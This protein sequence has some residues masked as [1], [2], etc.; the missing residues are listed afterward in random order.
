MAREPISLLTGSTLIL[1][2]CVALILG[3][4]GFQYIGG[5]PPCEMCY[6]QRYAHYA[7]IPLAAVASVLAWKAGDGVLVRMVLAATGLAILAGAGIAGFHS[8]VEYGWWPGPDTCSVSLDDPRATLLNPDAINVV[9][10]DEVPWS[11][12]GISM[13]GY[14][15]LI[16][17]VTG[18]FALWLVMKGRVNA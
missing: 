5:M 4:Y 10:C 6:W 8:G 16:S 18:L 11:L 2:V 9:R 12:F 15:F 7:A 13:A 14:N 17:T 3:A 1:G